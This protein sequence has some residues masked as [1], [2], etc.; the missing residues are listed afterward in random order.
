MEPYQIILLILL[1]SLLLYAA[2]AV[3]VLSNA[4]DF[5]IRLRRREKALMMLLAEKADILEQMAAKYER[6]KVT[7]TEDDKKAIAMLR[8]F[9]FEKID[10]ERVREVAEVVADVHTRLNYHRQNNKWIQSD[11]FLQRAEDTYAELDGNYRQSVAIYNADVAGYNYWLT[12][13]MYGVLVVLF[14]FRK[15]SPLN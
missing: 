6:S 5:R 7:L 1:V 4:R 9:S 15:R 11:L 2:V 8:G 13:P 3:Y 10:Q 12:I 14:G